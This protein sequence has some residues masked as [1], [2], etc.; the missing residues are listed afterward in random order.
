MGLALEKLV[1]KPSS[2]YITLHMNFEEALS[3]GVDE[4]PDN[5]EFFLSAHIW[6]TVCN[7]LRNITGWWSKLTVMVTLRS[8]EKLLSNAEYDRNSWVSVIDIREKNKEGQ[9]SG[10]REMK[11]CVWPKDS[12]EII[13]RKC[14]ETNNAP[15]PLVRESP[16]TLR[17][18]VVVLLWRLE[19]VVLATITKLDSYISLKMWGPEVTKVISHKYSSDQKKMKQIPRNLGTECIVEMVNIS[20]QH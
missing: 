6:N 1:H 11:Y 2:Q 9:G 8:L 3:M 7:N 17:I 16:A 14:K 13:S 15:T 4:S 19:I 5:R 18:L 12:P 20:C 10:N